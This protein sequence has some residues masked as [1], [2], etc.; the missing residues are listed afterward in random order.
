MISSHNT[1]SVNNK[2]WICVLLFLHF[3]ELNP[4]TQA[5]C[6]VFGCIIP[7]RQSSS[8]FLFTITTLAVI[9]SHSSFPFFR[10]A[11]QKHYSFDRS[12]EEREEEEKEEGAAAVT[13]YFS[14]NKNIIQMKDDVDD[15]ESY[16]TT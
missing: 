14:K 11:G 6:F 12:G 10:A 15:D 2:A 3:R 13:S 1:W 16:K 4:V 9:Y 5:I 7:I 8:V